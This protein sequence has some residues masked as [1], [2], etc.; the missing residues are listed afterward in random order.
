MISAGDVISPRWVTVRSTAWWG[1]KR[2]TS[3]RA[4]TSPAR[5]GLRTG[6][7]TKHAESPSRARGQVAGPEGRVG[8]YAAR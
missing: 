5:R 3:D 6:I 7:S 2:L 4:P 1:W 8:A